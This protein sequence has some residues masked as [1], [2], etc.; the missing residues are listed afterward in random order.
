MAYQNDIRSSVAPKGGGISFPLCFCP[1]IKF[2][3]ENFDGD[4]VPSGNH[5][6]AKM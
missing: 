1:S 5:T 3:R 4:K 6:H 2:P